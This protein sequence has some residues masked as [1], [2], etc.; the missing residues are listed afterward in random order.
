MAG[1]MKAT[2]IMEF[3]KAQE[4]I[5][6]QKEKLMKVNDVVLLSSYQNSL[7]LITDNH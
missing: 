5:Q 2:E 6:D 1:D 4:N 3:H 7:Q